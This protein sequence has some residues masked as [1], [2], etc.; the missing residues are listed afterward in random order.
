MPPIGMRTSATIQEAV[1]DIASRRSWM[2]ECIEDFRGE[3][4]RQEKRNRSR[5]CNDSLS[6]KEKA[7]AVADWRGHCFL[8]TPRNHK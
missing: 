5:S 3:S 4:R 1:T 6:G 7:M 8:V 2:R